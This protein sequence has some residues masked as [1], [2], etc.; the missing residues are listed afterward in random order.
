MEPVLVSDLRYRLGTMRRT[1]ARVAFYRQFVGPGELAFDVGAHVGDRT[2]LLLRAGASVVAVEPQ[3]L[4]REKLERAFGA[5]PR[6]TLVAE[7]VG[8]EAG[9]AELRWPAG[10]LALASMSDEWVGRV[11]ESGRFQ[12]EWD[13]RALVPVTTLDALIERYGAPSF[14]KIDVEGYEET[15]LGGLS[16]PI[17]TV[18]IE[19]IPENLDST[20]RALAK[21]GDLADYRFNY[22]LGESLALAE[23]RWLKRDELLE[24]LR[25]CVPRSFGDVYARVAG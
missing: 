9:T 21:F 18:S 5:D 15:V 12:A 17:R 25:T 7:A 13:D 2:E 23:Q 1:R 20:E 24:R 11:R 16:H 8:A 14:C 22:A 3:P 19:F 10:G 6:V 4:L